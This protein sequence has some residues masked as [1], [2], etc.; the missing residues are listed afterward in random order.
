[1][2][3]EGHLDFQAAA[4]AA[5]GAEGGEA[6]RRKRVVSENERAELEMECNI[7]RVSR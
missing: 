7:G 6:Y 4:A 5:E 2:G 3:E 1:V